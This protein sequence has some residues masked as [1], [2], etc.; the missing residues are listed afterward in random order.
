M[1]AT[2]PNYLNP[3][4]FAAYCRGPV[5]NMLDLLSIK[6]KP[7]SQK[8]KQVGARALGYSCFEAL[9]SRW[10]RVTRINERIHIEL[11]SIQ[12]G[13]LTLKAKNIVFTYDPDTNCFVG[14]ALRPGEE[15]R[16]LSVELSEYDEVCVVPLPEGAK[17]DALTTPKHT[18]LAAGVFHEE[19]VGT[20]DGSST[21]GD[22]RGSLSYQ[23]TTGEKVESGTVHFIRTYEGIIIDVY[24]PG[25]D[26][27]CFS[28][29]GV[30]FDD[31]QLNEEGPDQVNLADENPIYGGAFS[32]SYCWYK[33]DVD[34]D[35]NSRLL[36][37]N[38]GEEMD[39][40]DLLFKSQSEAI[41][42]ALSGSWGIDSD[43]LMES[44]AVLVKVTK[45]I[46]PSP[47]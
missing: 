42:G 37:I 31:R 29:G 13:R 12:N 30:T 32:E 10:A 5:M 18:I 26:T 25:V 43:G 22:T 6:L 9:S 16:A 41:E 40:S 1:L 24:A 27:E 46:V 23:I 4:D 33:T 8:L 38:P 3:V 2:K 19:G 15:G 17:L 7:G 47:F 21:L 11:C 28:T 34:H 45:T 36:H 20:L 14:M 35:E 44:G 39:I